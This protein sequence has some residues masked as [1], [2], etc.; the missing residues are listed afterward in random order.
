MRIN[1]KISLAFYCFSITRPI[2]HRRSLIS[3]WACL[4]ALQLCDLV[5]F[6][7]NLEIL[8][9]PRNLENVYSI[10]LQ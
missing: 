3:L 7:G 8:P 2:D 4:E 10:F 6:V 1:N 5:F 9:L